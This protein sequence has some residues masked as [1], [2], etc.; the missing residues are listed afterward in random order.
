MARVFI[1]AAPSEDEKAHRLAQA[2]QALGFDAAAEPPADAELTDAIDAAAAVVVLWAAGPASAWLTMVAALALDRKKLINAELDLEAAPTPFRAAPRIDFS[3]RDRIG[4][5]A[6]FQGLILELDKLA[7]TKA[8]EDALPEALALARGALLAPSLRQPSTMFG[9]IA[10]GLVTVLVLGGVGFGV[11][12]TIQAVRA[13]EIQ[14]A[15]PQLT[16]P[17]TEA[18]DAAPVAQPTAAEVATFD[19]RQLETQP[20]R[21]VAARIG[22]ADAI[23]QRAAQGDARSQTLACLGH[24]AGAEGFLP[25]PTAARA[26]CDAA[27]AQSEP[28][29]LYLSWVLQ[30]A[31]P[32]AGLSQTEA[33]AR[34][35]EAARLGWLPAQIDYGLTLA[36]DGRASLQ[37]QA[38]A[39]RLWLAAAERGDPR[40]QYQYARWLRDS[41]AGPRDPTAA[42]PFLER[43]AE[44]D[45]PEALHMLATLHRDGIGAARNEQR[46]LDLYEEAARQNY[47]PSMFN[48]ADMLRGG[49][50]VERTRAIALYHQLACM[51]D[52][53]QISALSRQRLR[54]LGER[55][56]C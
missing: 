39:G 6:R 15:L 40:G 36:A 13:G 55:A 32:H 12:R 44:R 50:N 5:A 1:A 20:W 2:V 24:M 16:R 49:A 18:A 38:E 56:T 26:F 8:D 33:N 7:P 37:A 52:Q 4:F 17:S 47:A 3:R 53:V 14:I 27:A 31:A 51:R 10:L 29:G 48:L 23:K 21:A 25:S 34:L 28:A 35:A 41:P 54:S 9:T 19:W 30:R 22:D 11:G 46:A 45:H 42:L 43:A